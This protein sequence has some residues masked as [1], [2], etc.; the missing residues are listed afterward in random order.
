[1]RTPG[2]SAE[3]TGRRV[4]EAAVTLFARKGFA[5]TGIR[6]L[7]QEAGVTTGALYH[8]MGTK[9]DLLVAIMRSCIDPLLAAAR[10]LTS[11][12]GQ[13]EWRLA[14][15]VE[16]HVWFHGANPLR[17]IIADT[18]L[19]ALEGPPAD[20]IIGLRDDYEAIWTGLLAEGAAAGRFE[21]PDERVAAIALLQ[22]CTGVAHWY[23]PGGRL[24]LDELCAMHAEMALAMV[25]A[26]SGRRPVRRA[27][28]R[29][30]RPD[31]HLPADAA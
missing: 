1:M 5:A 21:V 24:Q 13:P 9:D 8:Y 27:S 22:L 31:A 7:A 14:A 20:E 10:E 18:E 3:E 11:R 30:P 6:E 17:T 16:M 19:R 15:L 28:L 29:L 2:A 25:R 26:R 4:R 23:R 12:D